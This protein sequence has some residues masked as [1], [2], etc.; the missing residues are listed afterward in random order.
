MAEFSDKIQALMDEMYDKW[1]KGDNKRTSHLLLLSPSVPRIYLPICPS[2][3]FQ[4]VSL[5]VV[6]SVYF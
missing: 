5:V 2:A 6:D 3:V 4:A 1:Q